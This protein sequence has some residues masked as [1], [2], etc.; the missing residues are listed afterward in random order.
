MTSN[1]STYINKIKKE[2]KYTAQIENILRFLSTNAQWYF[3]YAFVLVQKAKSLGRNGALKKHDK[4][5]HH[6][7]MF[8]VSISKMALLSV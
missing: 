1:R 6:W 8:G 4:F 3:S 5:I 7:N 2:Q